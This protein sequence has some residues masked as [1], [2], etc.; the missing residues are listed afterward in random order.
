MSNEATA[1]GGRGRSWLRPSFALAVGVVVVIASLVVIADRIPPAIPA[2]AAAQPVAHVQPTNGT[3]GRCLERL[4]RGA[5]FADLC[6]Q[7]Y[8]VTNEADLEKDYYALEFSGSFQ[9]MRWLV[10]RSKLLVE[11]AGGVFV[12]WPIGTYK[13]ACQ[14]LPVDGLSAVSE[15]QETVCGRTD[16][17]SNTSAWTHQATWTCESCVLLDATTRAI[18]LTNTVGV[19]E[20]TTPSWDLF[21]DGGS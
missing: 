20:G 4:Q 17:I 12:G 14:E 13:G 16:A 7:A 9:G 11:P 10:V 5:G 18:T 3:D 2:S 6:W 15:R 19:P 21:A 1:P 8:R